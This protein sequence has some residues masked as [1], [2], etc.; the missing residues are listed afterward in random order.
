MAYIGR[1]PGNSGVTFKSFTASGADTYSLDESA[2][3]NSVI[4]SIGGVL[5]KP[6]TDYSVSGTT[7]TTTETIATGIV[8]DTYIIHDAGGSTPVIEDNSVTTSKIVDNHV[9]GA[10]IAMG[11]DAAGDILYYNGTDYVRLAKG[12][13]LQQLRINSGASAPEWATV[14]TSADFEFV[15]SQTASSSS[16][17]AFTNMADGYDYEYVLEHVLPANDSVYMK[18]EL[19]V[20]GP[21]Y[22]T[23][24]YL[25]GGHAIQQATSLGGNLT[26]HIH[27]PYTSETFGNGSGEGLQFATLYLASPAVSA[28]QTCYRFVGEFM[29]ESTRQCFFSGG[30]RYNSAEAHTSVKFEMSGGNIASGRFWQYRRKRS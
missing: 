1:E 4:V 29:D 13:A 20:A 24:S 18:I 22:R 9:T 16:D 30:G 26:D 23:S 12:T 28:N 6:V 21:T 19:G 7:L 14:T 17:I 25:S 5:Q 8:I 3:T 11:S 10:K 15:S 27:G 2:S